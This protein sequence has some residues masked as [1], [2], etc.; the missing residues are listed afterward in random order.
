MTCRR[1]QS[2]QVVHYRNDLF[3][4]WFCP[5]C[6]NE[7]VNEYV[8]SAELPAPAALARDRARSSGDVQ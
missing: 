8:E 7:L 3:D 4:G 1:C 6:V 5:R 2:E